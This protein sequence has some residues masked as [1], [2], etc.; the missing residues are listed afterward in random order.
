MNSKIYASV[1]LS[2]LGIG[3]VGCQGDQGNSRG[4]RHGGNG[5]TGWAS[6]DFEAANSQSDESSLSLADGA[7]AAPVVAYKISVNCDDVTPL[8]VEEA[9]F[10]LPLGAKNCVA[11]L[12][13]IK[14]GQKNYIE[15][16]GGSGFKTYSVSEIGQFVN[17]KDAGDKL[18]VRVRKQLPSPLNEDASIQYDY[19]NIQSFE[20][21]DGTREGIDNAIVTGGQAA[22]QIKVTSARLEKNGLVVHVA[23]TEASGF[24]SSI[25]KDMKCAGANV[26]PMQFAI[27]YRTDNAIPAESELKKIIGTDSNDKTALKLNPEFMAVDKTLKFNFKDVKDSKYYLLVAANGS[28][29]TYGFIR[30]S[31]GNI[32]AATECP[33]QGAQANFILKSTDTVTGIGHWRDTN[34]CNVWLRPTLDKVISSKRFSQCPAAKPGEAAGK[35]LLPYGTDMKA[36]YDRNIKDLAF[37]DAPKLGAQDTTFWMAGGRV[38]DMATGKFREVR[39]IGPNEKHSVLCF[40]KRD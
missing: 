39:D 24:S 26:S 35:R 5:S 8:E 11:K 36:A 22:P 3:L 38:F 4:R 9:P 1:L 25:M 23:C 16:A 15:P 27:G 18:F 10:D 6:I 30:M 37:G 34:G 2:V 14:I 33:A 7:D 40:I 31:G 17:D 12:K 21:I 19:S 28:S 32:A 20:T 29:Y 13:S